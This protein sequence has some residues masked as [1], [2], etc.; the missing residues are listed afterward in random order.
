MGNF[1]GIQPVKVYTISLRILVGVG[2]DRNMDQVLVD[3]IIRDA[4]TH[5]IVFQGEIPW[6]LLMVS[7]SRRSRN[8]LRP[9]DVL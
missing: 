6:S 5:M 4:E 1:E 8:R 2:G 3:T 9:D 7:I